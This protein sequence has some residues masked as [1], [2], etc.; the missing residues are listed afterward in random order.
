M[1]ITACGEPLVTENGKILFYTPGMSLLRFYRNTLSVI[2]GLNVQSWQCR[3][4][5]C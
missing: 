3:C 5:V 2:C 1:V 4:F